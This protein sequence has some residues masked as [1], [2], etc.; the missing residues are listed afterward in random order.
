MDSSVHS[1]KNGSAKVKMSGVGEGMTVME[2]ILEDPTE[3]AGDQA[4]RDGD[5]SVAESKRPRLA[6]SVVA[7]KEAAARDHE[8]QETLKLYQKEANE[9]RKKTVQIACYQILLALIRRDPFHLF[10]EPVT[11]EGY[12]TLVQKPIDYGKIRKKLLSEKYTSLSAFVIDCKLVCDNALA[13]NP[14]SSL[15]YKTAKEMRDVIDVMQKR[16]HDWIGTIKDAHTNY[17]LHK[18]RP[19][20]PIGESGFS[21]EPFEELRQKWPEAVLMLENE[22]DLRKKVESDFMRTKENELAYYGALAVR[23]TS[24]AAAACM[25]PYPDS[26]GIHSVV[27]RRSAEQDEQLRQFVDEQVVEATKPI[28][29]KDV[30]SW[31]EEALVRL[32]KKVQKIRLERRTITENGCS[33]CDGVLMDEEW[34]MALNADATHPGKPRKKGDGDIPRVDHTRILLSTGL[35]SAKTCQRIVSRK[36][37]QILDEN[38]NDSIHDACV[39]VRGSRIH[40]MGLFADQPFN[41]GDVVAEYIGE[42]VVNPVAEAREKSYGE[43]RIP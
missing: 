23:R 19:K 8:H 7:S 20:Q 26:L 5:G 39:S 29:L 16:A 30:S 17:L 6:R 24:A 43:Q 12:S 2:T 40:G 21:T 36:P 25:A 27:A 33:R 15:Y 14:P 3:D 31:R 35:G 42:Y 11:A 28:M 4:S 22:D 32:M 10:A 1:S 41:K 34:K 13:Y 9:L 18:E 38:G 37:E